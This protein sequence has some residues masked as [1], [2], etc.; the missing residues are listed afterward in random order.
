MAFTALELASIANGV[1][2]YNIKGQP[3][4]QTIQDKPLLNHMMKVQKSFGAGKENIT[5]S[6][7]GEYTTTIMGY[8]HDDT[9]NYANPA[10]L[11]RTQ[12]PWKE[13]HAGINFTGTELKKSGISVV[14]STTGARTSNHSDTE[15]TVLV[16][17][18]DDKIEDMQEGWARGMNEM[19]WRDGSQDAKQVPGVL[20]ILFD[21][22]DTGITGGIDRAVNAW[23]RNRASL[24]IASNSSTWEDQ[25]LV[26]ELQKEYRQLRRFGGKPNLFLCGSDFLDAF[27]MEL[28]VKGV[29]TQTGWAK[30]GGTID[31]SVADVAF[32]GV[33]LEYDPT[34]DDLSRPKYGY[35][36]DTRRLR[37]YVMEGEDRKTHTPARPA[38][39]YVYYRAMTWT[40]GLC[41][42][43]LN[44]HGVYSIA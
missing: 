32:K 16:N 8:T 10:N 6:V 21:S 36:M 23:W 41:A 20:S 11:K 25:P 5:E 35:W 27:E 43:Q 4:S 13:I 33:R 7:K 30:Q 1:L 9:V 2:D 17:L 26:R 40:G 15:M 24:D 29:Y 37:P 19:F 3:L 34:L 38:E 14:D 28:R 12:Y 31:A 18:L 39:K 22:P 42:T 44:C